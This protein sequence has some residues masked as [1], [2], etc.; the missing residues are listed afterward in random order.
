[1]SFVHYLTI[2]RFSYGE[3]APTPSLADRVVAHFIPGGLQRLEEVAGSI[4]PFS[5]A[6][7]MILEDALR[8]RH[9]IEASLRD[10]LTHQGLLCIPYIGF[11]FRRPIAEHVAVI[12]HELFG[13]VA[14][15]RGEM[16]SLASLRM[17][18]ARYAR[19]NAECK[20][21]RAIEDDGERVR[22]IVQ[23][24]RRPGNDPRCIPV[25]IGLD[26][27]EGID[28]TALPHLIAALSSDAESVRM[29]AARSLE[30]LGTA[31]AAAIPTLTA[32]VRDSQPPDAEDAVVALAAMGPAAEESLLLAT[33]HWDR[34]VRYRAI[35]V[36]GNMSH[37]SD[38]AR[39]RLAEIG[40]K[41]RKDE[42]AREAR[43]ALARL[44][45]ANE[46]NE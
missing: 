33:T 31:A 9:D 40:A 27:I 1:M 16:H 39:A 13:A 19:Q 44:R 18:S 12:A 37:A 3:D 28:A 34:S 41:G 32:I 42:D 24:L 6:D 36:L 26:A 2:G 5:D 17:T 11:A 46:T 30:R 4:E 8:R 29:F 45:R 43:R 14:G 10:Y 35:W 20:R 15:E 22:Q 7:V 21:L 23:D 25:S 38:A